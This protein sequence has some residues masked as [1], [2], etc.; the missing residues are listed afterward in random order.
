LE[1]INSIVENIQKN[2]LDAYKTQQDYYDELEKENVSSSLQAGGTSKNI[3]D[4][5]A[6]G[7]F[8]YRGKGVD[9]LNLKTADEHNLSRSVISD[10]TF[11][12]SDTFWVNDF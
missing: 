10:L 3:A 2:A 12:I 9:Q 11:G 8:N 6:K 7:A 1:N 5:I 4:F